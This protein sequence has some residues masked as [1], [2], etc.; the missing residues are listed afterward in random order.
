MAV[1]KVSCLVIDVLLILE[2]S[3]Y[4]RS[5]QQMVR[6]SGFR[7]PFLYFQEYTP[8]YGTTIV[9]SSQV[10]V[11]RDPVAI[12][13]IFSSPHPYAGSGEHCE[14][15]LVEVGRRRSLSEAAW[16]RNWPRSRYDRTGS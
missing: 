3:Q 15:W 9:K 16:Y 13:Q 1:L 5:Q 12:I 8:I 10:V 6:S 14:V 2:F 4:V 7:V 11:L